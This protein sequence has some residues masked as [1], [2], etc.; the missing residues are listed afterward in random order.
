MEWVL[1]IIVAGLAAIA[2]IILIYGNIVARRLP[3]NCPARFLSRPRIDQKVVVCVG[4]SITHGRV[5]ANYVDLLGTRLG[6]DYQVVNAGIN[7]E[8]AWNVLQRIDEVITCRPDYITILIGTNDANTT[9]DR[10]NQREALRAMKLPQVPTA[11]WYRESLEEICRQLSAR[12]TA[13]IALLSLPP[14]GEDFTHVGYQRTM[15]YSTIIRETAARHGLTYLPLHETMTAVLRQY[16]QPA[17]LSYD[18]GISLVMYKGIFDH[19]IRHK[20]YNDI[21]AANGFQFLTDFLHLNE[22][23]AELVAGIVAGFVSD[24]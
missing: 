16:N 22:R 17:K 18:D 23:G 6:E 4:D 24:L 5:S 12:T 19:I 9:L 8:L 10:K 14:I 1:L 20:N 7:G 15:E 21:A 11:E 3:I 2:G 13:Q